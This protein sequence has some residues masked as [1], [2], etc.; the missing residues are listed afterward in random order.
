[1]NLP[2]DAL[3]YL[4]LQR[5]AYI[6]GEA[7]DAEARF[8]ADV[9]E[10][11][12]EIEPFLPPPKRE[13]RFM[14]IGCGI[15]FGLLALLKARGPDHRFVGVDRGRVSPEIAYGFSKAPSAYNS[16]HVTRAVLIAA[17]V[18]PE[19]IECV[20]IDVEAFPS[21]RADVVTSTYAWAFHFP[22]ERYLKEVE[23]AL[24]PDGVVI[25]DVRRSV[26]QEEVLRKSF[27]VVHVWPAPHGKSDRLVLKRK[28]AA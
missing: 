1:M 23:A 6:K 20:D 11:A 9:A 13:M 10:F 25:L 27:D 7:C 24:A 17:G 21:G 3:R 4:A 18:A 19:R 5:P 15:G 16:L 28:S 2:A 14:D 26:G 8:A 12:D 22:V